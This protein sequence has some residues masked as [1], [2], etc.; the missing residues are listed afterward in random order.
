MTDSVSTDEVSAD[1]G[2]ESGDTDLARASTDESKGAK[3]D[4]T[5]E[6]STLAEKMG[7]SVEEVISRLVKAPKPE[8]AAEA[9]I[10]NKP[11]EQEKAPEEGIELFI[12]SQEELTATI[13]FES[14]DR[15]ILD[16]LD[17]QRAL[18]LIQKSDTS[19][20]KWSQPGIE[21]DAGTYFYDRETKAAVDPR[22]FKGNTVFRKDFKL[23][24]L[25]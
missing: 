16:K 22:T 12:L 1:S 14:E 3:I 4:I 10:E 19:V 23:T 25:P 24:R 17:R 7:L 18:D 11:P 20:S 8:Q 9:P 15:K 6:V 2:A 5:P 13:V 21:V